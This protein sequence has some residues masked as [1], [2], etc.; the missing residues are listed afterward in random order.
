[1]SYIEVGFSS[2]QRE[3]M[4][5]YDLIMITRLGGTLMNTDNCVGDRIR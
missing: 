2:L 5:K 3:M 1:M 4:N